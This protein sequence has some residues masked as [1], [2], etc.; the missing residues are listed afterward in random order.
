MNYFSFLLKGVAFFALFVTMS[1]R[2][3]QPVLKEDLSVRRFD[4][5]C[6]QDTVLLKRVL[7]D[8]LIYMHSNG[9]KETKTSFIQSVKEQKIVY[10]NIH[11]E[12]VEFRKYDRTIIGNGLIYVEGMYQQQPFQIKLFFTEIYYKKKGIWQLVSWQSLKI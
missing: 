4:A 11:I 2:G 5:M 3:V 6:S 1:C 12:E 8:D 7:A 9:L 10:Q